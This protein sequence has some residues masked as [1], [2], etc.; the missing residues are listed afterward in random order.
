MFY[1][2][3]FVCGNNCITLSMI[4]VDLYSLF[5]E[6]LTYFSLSATSLKGL[7]GADIFVVIN[8]LLW[9]EISVSH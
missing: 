8:G 2:I 6:D 3:D 1:A 5:W 9:T 4:Q 7:S